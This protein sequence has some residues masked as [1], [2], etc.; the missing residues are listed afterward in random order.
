MDLVSDVVIDGN[1]AWVVGMSTG[2]SRRTRTCDRHSAQLN[3]HD[4]YE[5]EYTQWWFALPS[6]TEVIVRG[7][8]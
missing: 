4:P 8:Y 6:N 3:E 7:R 1:V 2:C 5:Y